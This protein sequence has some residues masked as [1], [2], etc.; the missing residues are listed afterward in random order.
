[1]SLMLIGLG[2]LGSWVLEFLVRTPYV[3][4]LILADVN[5]DRALRI[6][7]RALMGAVHQGFHPKIDFVKIDLFDVDKTSESIKQLKPFIIFNSTTLFSWWMTELL[8][9]NIQEKVEQA[10]FGPWLPMHLTLLYKLMQAVKK[11]GIKT[12][13]VNASF[14]DATHPVLCKVGLEPMVG[15]GNMDLLVPRIQYIISNKLKVPIRDVSVF[16][17]AHHFHVTALRK[18]HSTM[19]APYYLKILVEDKDIT[20]KL[21]P[22]TILSEVGRIP[23]PFGR[24]MHP[25]VASSAVKN[26]TAIL[27]DSGLLTH[28]PGPKGLVGGYPIR[29]FSDE[30]QIVLPEELDIRKAVEINLEAQRFDG[31]EQI[32][33]D[34]TVVFTDKSYKI[35]EETLGYSCKELRLEECED[36]ARELSEILKKITKKDGGY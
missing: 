11:S 19:G 6:I 29:L 10:G 30:V 28:A 27:Q 18:Y 31:I 20:S 25:Q 8:P 33:N 32:K 35:M 15:I 22:E 34:G 26:I 1:M 23:L 2:D 36:R 4:R 24:E 9:A 14:P 13:V 12:R 21:D 3:N 7:N 17:V 5:E 16:L